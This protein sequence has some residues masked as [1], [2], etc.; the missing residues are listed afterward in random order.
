M[1][2]IRI[3]TL[4]EADEHT[5]S[6]VRQLVP[7]GFESLQVTFW[8]ETKVA[9]PQLADAVKR[10]IGDADVVVD[11]L[12]IYGNPLQDDVTVQAWEQLIDHAHLFGATVVAGFAGRLDGRPVDESLPRFKQ[13]F[14]PLAERAAEKGLR[15]A[16]EHCPWE[17]TWQ[18]GE[19]NMAVSPVA[20]ERMFEAVPHDD[21]GLEWDPAHTIGSFADPIGQLRTW[22]PRVFHVHGKDATMHW[23][24]IRTQGIRGPQPYH[25]HRTPGFGDAD[26]SEIITI[27][28]AAGYQ[29][30]IDVEGW[31]D[32][33]YKDELEMTGQVHALHHLKRCRGGDVVP[34]P[35]ARS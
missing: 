13:V 24:V 26:W 11:A 6:Y 28:R 29:G 17:G 21:V 5:E 1:R 16:F 25:D 19:M 18:T 27:L 33:V 14:G 35:D 20:W 30:T 9:L 10:G 34:N 4:V 7:H 15:I 31:H 2:Q 32:P 8:H 3:G 12:G 22:A 23:D